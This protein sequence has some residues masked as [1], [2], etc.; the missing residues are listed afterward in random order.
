M[1]AP[2]RMRARFSAQ[3]DYR[4]LKFVGCLPCIFDTSTYDVSDRVVPVCSAA[5]SSNEAREPMFQ[6]LIADDDPTYVYLIRRMMKQAREACE[7]HRVADGVEAMQ[8]LHKEGPFH[9]A[10]RPDLILMDLKMPRL[11][12]AEALSA[13]KNDPLLRAIPVVVLSAGAPSAQVRELYERGAACF[14]EKTGDV[15]RLAEFV[16]VLETLWIT[17]LSKGREQDNEQSIP[18]LELEARSRCQE[19]AR[20]VVELL[21]AVQELSGLHD[22]QIRAILQSDPEYA[23]FDV[24]IH[25]ATERKHQAKY[26]YIRHVESHGCRDQHGIAESGRSKR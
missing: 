13:I 26:A 14:V 24:L 19:Q 6:I 21:A 5:Q 9:D 20:W 4:A 7:V 25:M 10:P 22:Q 2:A 17:G 3:K 12:G 18:V 16:R 15:D 1:D 11:S 23:R 8:F